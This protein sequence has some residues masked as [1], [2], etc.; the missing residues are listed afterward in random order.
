MK[1]V[2]TFQPRK[3]LFSTTVRNAKPDA[4]FWIL[5]LKTKHRQIFCLA[6]MVHIAVQERRVATTKKKNLL[7]F[8]E[9]FPP[10]TIKHTWAWTW[11]KRGRSYSIYGIFLSTPHWLIQLTKTSLTFSFYTLSV[12]IKATWFCQSPTTVL[13]GLS[14]LHQI[15]WLWL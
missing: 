15:Q 7:H 11:T 5:V 13:S 2:F 1:N 10:F 6:V 12:Y 8:E 9:I 14:T 3:C 4:T